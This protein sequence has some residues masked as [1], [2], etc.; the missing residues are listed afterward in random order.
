M[1]GNVGDT[2]R[3]R[4]IISYLQRKAVT[5]LDRI[6]LDDR[7]IR[8]DDRKMEGGSDVLYT[9]LRAVDPCYTSNSI[10]KEYITPRQWVYITYL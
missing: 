7:K 3:L 6:F 1:V 9:N 5:F 2:Q 10:I 8:F 4:Y